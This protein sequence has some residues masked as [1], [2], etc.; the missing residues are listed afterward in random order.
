[1]EELNLDEFTHSFKHHLFVRFYCLPIHCRINRR[2][3]YPSPTWPGRFSQPD[4]HCF[5]LNTCK[6]NAS[7]CG[8]I[9]LSYPTPAAQRL[10]A[11][12]Q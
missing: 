2:Y 12:G 3:T 10:S 5:T 6:L 4:T 8:P 11:P 9:I 1:M 7:G